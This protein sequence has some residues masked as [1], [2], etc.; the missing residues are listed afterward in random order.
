[1]AKKKRIDIDILD[2]EYQQD[3]PHWLDP[4]ER[5]A[6]RFDED[7]KRKQK[8]RTDEIMEK[9]RKSKRRRRDEED[10]DE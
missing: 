7:R 8:E 1:M 2:M 10:D 3:L 9:G 5:Y 6:G 4:V